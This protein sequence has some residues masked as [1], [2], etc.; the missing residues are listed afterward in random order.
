MSE[1]DLFGDLKNIRLDKGM[2]LEQVSEQSRI[3]L[4]Y[5]Q[6]LES[7]E[8]LKIPEVYDKMFFRGYLK[9]LDLNEDEYY[10]R[11]LEYRKK[12]RVDK[13][14]GVINF[15]REDESGKK[16]NISRNI[17]VIIPLV[18]VIIVVWLLIQ[19]TQII[20][21]VSDEPVEEIDIQNIVQKMEQKIIIPADTTG[22]DTT[23]IVGLNLDIIGL[24][25]T[26]FRVVVDE[27]DTLEY[28]LSR[29]NKISL[30]AINSCEFLIGRADGLR[31]R[32]NGRE[33]G[34]IGV[35]STVVRYMRVDS[36]GITAK[37]FKQK[38][39]ES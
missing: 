22:K 15:I 5:L 31:I 17:L 28:L 34:R 1:N 11:F 8:L 35:D 9:S 33:L 12:L 19:N 18:V 10:D 23:Q 3:Q 14:T 36:T 13:T 25:R 16:F 30:E 24:K 26:W 4:K 20:S 39:E 7:G 27:K 29:G 32:M 2:S 37:V 21:S 38:A 6:A